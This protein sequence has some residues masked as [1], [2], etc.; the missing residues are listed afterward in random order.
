ME[1]CGGRRP[2]ENVQLFEE[3]LAAL[4]H[5]RKRWNGRV[6]HAPDRS[7]GARAAEAEL[8]AARHFRLDVA[9]DDQRHDPRLEL[10]PFG[11]IGEGRAP[12]RQD[13]WC[14]T[15]GD[16]THLLI[17]DPDRVSY[18]LIR[19]PDGTWRGSR[20]LHNV[21]TATLLAVGGDGSGQSTPGPG[22]A[23]ELLRA[24]G[25]PNHDATNWARFREAATLMAQVEPGFLSRLRELAAIMDEKDLQNLV[26]ALTPPARQVLQS[27]EDVLARFYQSTI[28]FDG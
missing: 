9:A 23:D 15:R 11:E 19:Q 26:D 17:R 18:D 14:E 16:G 7:V 24:I 21:T 12:Y 3:S 6:F 25:Y 1:L 28:D 5:L 8:V 22:L 13:W 20:F 10:L 27:S 4:D 2:G